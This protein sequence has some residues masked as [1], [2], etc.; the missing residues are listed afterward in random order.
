MRDAITN[1]EHIWHASR[2]MQEKKQ[3]GRRVLAK[4]AAC[5]SA[6]AHRQLQDNCHFT[7]LML[8]HLTLHASAFN[9]LRR[10]SSEH[11]PF[12]VVASN[13]SCLTLH[14]SA[15]NTLRRISSEHVPFGV[16]APKTSC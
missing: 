16:I 14:A 1:T 5:L 7:Y 3:K 9:T 2:R 10:F 13:T 4:N 12:C 8:Q 11:D 15:F 6:W